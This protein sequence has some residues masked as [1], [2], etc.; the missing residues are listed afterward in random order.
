[1]PDGDPP[2]RASS[3][4]PN[5]INARMHG[6]RARD[7]GRIDRRRSVDRRVLETIC[8]LEEALGDRL[9]PQ[10]ALI[11]ANVGRRLRDL[12]WSRRAARPVATYSG[13]SERTATV[14]GEVKRKQKRRGTGCAPVEQVVP[15]SATRPGKVGHA[16]NG[17]CCWSIGREK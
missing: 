3:A 7:A 12:A 17:A 1:M 9:T 10:R 16:R 6:L 8:A 2:K 14:A 13:G 4:Q 15:R 5:N 11:L